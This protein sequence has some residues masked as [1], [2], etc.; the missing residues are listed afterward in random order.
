MK[1]FLRT[2]QK[3]VTHGEA[4]AIGLIAETWLSN[5]CLGLQKDDLRDIGEYLINFFPKINLNVIS[6]EQFFNVLLQDKKNKNDKIMVSLIRNI[7]DCVIDYPVSR[8]LCWN[9]LNFYKS[10]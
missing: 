8:A 10:L 2:N 6:K 1:L 3:S 5:Q 4:V 9:A 7:G